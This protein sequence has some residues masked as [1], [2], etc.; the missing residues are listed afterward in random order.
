M[1]S[2]DVKKEKKHLTNT[3]RIVVNGAETSSKWK[4]RGTEVNREDSSIVIMCEKASAVNAESRED[5]VDSPSFGSSEKNNPTFIGKR[6]ADIRDRLTKSLAAAA[7]AIVDEGPTDC[8]SLTATMRSCSWR[9]SAEIA[10]DVT[11]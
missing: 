5:S 4:S 8:D 11:S 6:M 3:K 10:E 1:I 7:A 9:D 2:Q